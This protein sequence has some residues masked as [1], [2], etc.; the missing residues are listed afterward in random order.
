VGF[1][2]VALQPVESVATRKMDNNF[3]ATTVYQ[4]RREVRGL[5]KPYTLRY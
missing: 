1:L 5:R 2:A 4:M 3:I